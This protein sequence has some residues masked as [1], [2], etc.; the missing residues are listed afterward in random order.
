MKCK[1]CGNELLDG[2]VFCQACG[3]RQDEP[4][5]EVKQEETKAEETKAEEKPVEEKK[6]ESSAQPEAQAQP[7]PEA[8]AQA[9]V[10]P[11]AQPQAGE[12]KK[13]SPLPIIIGIVAAVAVIALI[14][15]G[16]K[17]IGGLGSKGG[18]STAVAYVS[19]GTLCVIE[20][21]AAKEP[22][23]IE[24]CDLDIDESAYLPYNFI[25]WS[26]DHKSIYFFDDVDSDGVGD[27]CYVQIS[28]LGKDKTKNESKIVV[29]DDN[30]YI[31]SLTLLSN[32][33]IL[34]LT[35]K[36][37][38]CVYGGKEP[39]ELA[40]DVDDY[41]KTDDGKGIY[42]LSDYEEEGYT[43]SYMPISG[44]D[45]TELDD[46]VDY[47]SRVEGNSV[48]YIKSE[49]DEDYN[50]SRSLFIGE[51]DGSTEEITDA[52]G[53]MGSITDNGFYYTE[54]APSTVTLYDYIDDPYA[55]S[56]ENAVEPVYPDTDA[57]FVSANA[58]EVFDDYKLGRII[59][60]F[61]GDPVAYME[62][63]CWSYT[64][65]GK[66][67]YY[68]YNSDTYEEYY[69][70]ITAGV[71]YRYDYDTM[72][73]AR[74]K[75]YDDQEA[76]Y[77]IQSRIYL[78]DALKEY[79]VDPGYVALYYYHD[80]KSEEIVSECKDVSLV[81]IGLDTP[82]ALYHEADSSSVEKLSIDDIDYAYDAY[83]RLFGYSA[84]SDYGKIL[85]AV[86]NDVNLEL[87]E[88]GMIGNIGGSSTDSRIAVEVRNEDGAD[89]IL[90]NIKGS[91]LEQDSKFD[92][93]AE[94]VSGFTG[95]KVYFLK[96]VSDN[97]STADVFIYDGK[98][99][100]KVIKNVSIYES[101][102]VF[103]TGSMIF[104]DDNGKAIL[105]NASGDEI[106]KLGD[107]ETMWRDVN[108][109]SDKK[110]I[111]VADEKL[112]YFNGKETFK[113]ANRIEY[114]R[115]VSTSGS[116]LTTYNYGYGVD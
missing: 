23:I 50:Y 61:D 115:F 19:K 48:V 63:N 78:R 2:A 16:I 114:V 65:N 80:G 39:E 58:E 104:S 12:T 112:C 98:D 13:K 28:K 43:L 34:Y 17:L 74:D 116:T 64:I 105:Y 81:Y 76:W 37:K 100:T 33:K 54:E 70:D 35:S 73:A 97:G 110:I 32:G 40:K 107:I 77:D 95:G 111:F 102:M 108:Y 92:D 49:Y 1:N 46:E 3:T 71:Y 14:V 59:K 79:E 75:Y 53:I 6:E 101:G 109:I 24:V 8:Q 31:S 45:S 88:S 60:K 84:A 44:E 72:Q 22:K 56:D 57:G 90:Y 55:S 62:D 21:A 66:D 42:Y 99:N 52:L 41:Y 29:I 96:N 30:V 85:Y 51:T 36:D 83:D 18:S 25:T 20:D 103:S 9:P 67:Y 47:I 11:Q 69:Y 89:Y 94:I 68:I 26:D 87:G 7:Q 106:V 27:L 15:L 91:S 86:G 38:L 5:T 10:Q 4:A 82:M 93:E 113:I